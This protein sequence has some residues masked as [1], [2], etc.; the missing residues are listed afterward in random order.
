MPLPQPQIG[1]IVHYSYV[2]RDHTRTIGPEGKDRPCLIMAI[3]QDTK[4]KAEVK[5]LYLPITH[6]EPTETSGALEIPVNVRYAAGL[7]GYRQWIII[8]EGNLD[9]WPFDISHI[10]NQPGR[11][12]YGVLTPGFFANVQ[13]AW[14]TLY[15]LKRF[16]LVARQT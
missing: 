14:L 1:L 12:N 3:Q 9:V 8:A 5:V 15:T 4:D 13:K 11:F 10:P 2:F 16:S 6:T 7:D